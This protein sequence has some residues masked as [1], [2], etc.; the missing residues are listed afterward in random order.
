MT[1]CAKGGNPVSE[2]SAGGVPNRLNPPIAN[3]ASEA[4]AAINADDGA[5]KIVLFMWLKVAEINNKLNT[6]PNGPSARN[7]I[8][9]AHNHNSWRT[10]WLLSVMLGLISLPWVPVS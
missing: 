6:V 5:Q 7:R 3:V 10:V 1:R 2:A 9:M 4:G 8:Q